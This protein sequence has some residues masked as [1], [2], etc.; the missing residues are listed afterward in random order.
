MST[1]LIE[2]DFQPI[3]TLFFFN[4]PSTTSVVKQAAGYNIH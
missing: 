3:E 4:I 2:E 1:L